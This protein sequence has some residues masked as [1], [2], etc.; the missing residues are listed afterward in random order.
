MKPFA[1]L[2]CD[3]TTLYLID[4][5]NLRSS[6]EMMSECGGRQ[7]MREYLAEH[8]R[9]SYVDDV[10][11][12]WGFY[13]RLNGLIAGLCTLWLKDGVAQ[14]SAETF[15]HWRG[16]GVSSGTKPALFHLAFAM[17][18]F[19]RVETACLASDE[20]AKKAIEKTPGFEFSGMEI[21]TGEDG[22]EI[23]EFRYVITRETWEAAYKDNKVD[24]I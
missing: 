1:G 22:A 11:Q 4:D 5:W 14:T 8:Y 7:A 9:P 15:P 16:M 13:V 21:R 24:V 12:R 19:D 3:K 17:L 2:R 18:G 23:E 10:R 20:A 6:A